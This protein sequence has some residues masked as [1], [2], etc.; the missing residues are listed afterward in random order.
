MGILMVMMDYF[1]IDVFLYL[2]RK[3]YVLP[4]SMDFIMEK[5][6]GI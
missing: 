1:M 2:Y 4:I 3:L 6:T 5:L